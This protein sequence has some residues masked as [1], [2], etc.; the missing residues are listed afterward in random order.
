MYLQ[1][2]ELREIDII[3]R[4]TNFDLITHKLALAL[5]PILCTIPE[6]SYVNMVYWC[7]LASL[8]TTSYF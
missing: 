6:Y 1:F 7:K 2:L 4:K 8:S 3:G 5:L